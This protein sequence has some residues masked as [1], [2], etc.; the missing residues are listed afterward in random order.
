M[1]AEE[2][3]SLDHPSRREI[4]GSDSQV[5]LGTLIKGRSSSPSLNNELVMYHEGIY[6]ETSVNRADDPTRGKKIRGPSREKPSWWTALAR[7]EFEEFDEWLRNLQIHPD[8]VSGLPPF[9]EILH[10]ELREEAVDEEIKS[11]FVKAL[12]KS[13]RKEKKDEERAA[14]REGLR[15]RQPEAGGLSLPTFRLKVQKE[16]MRTMA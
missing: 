14:D 11:M 16:R 9:S 10:G 15:Y 6:Y 4:Y 13:R 8:E 3:H 2:I 12:G 1:H 5:A 7:G